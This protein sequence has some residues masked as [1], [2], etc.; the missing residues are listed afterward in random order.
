M[1]FYVITKKHIHDGFFAKFIHVLMHL[2]IAEK[3]G[4][5]PFIDFQTPINNLHDPQNTQTNNT[6]EYC[7]EQ[8]YTIED[9]Y[10]SNPI[11][12]DGLYQSFYNAHGK[13]FRSKE[14]TSLFHDLYKKYIKVKPEIL[15]KLNTEITQYK[16]LGVHC[17]RSDMS[18]SHPEI[19]L[20]YSN[21]IFFE[22]TM[23]IFN[24]GNFEKI[25]LAT[26]EINILEHF[27]NTI[28]DKV[29][30]HDCFRVLPNEQPVTKMSDR[31]MHRTLQC[32]EVLIDALNLSKCN[33]LL[34]GISGVSNSVTFIN[35]LKFDEVY[36]FDEID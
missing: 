17:R 32:Q 36:Y 14:L 6:W 31:F 16:T 10:N 24:D 22:K 20:N 9:V 13:H 23:K 1:S 15:E 25:Y 5:I 19:A 33:S 29:F 12:S 4:L 27:K 30:Y 26:E 34:C 11:L 3:K 8:G 21:E 7:F 28:P 2:T 18:L 35:G